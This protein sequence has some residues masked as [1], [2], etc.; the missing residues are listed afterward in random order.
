[1]LFGVAPIDPRTD[2]G[3]DAAAARD[4][5]ESS[6][7][8]AVELSRQLR[9]MACR[10]SA[11]L[12]PA[13]EEGECYPGFFRVGAD[14][15]AVVLARLCLTVRERDGCPEI[16]DL[17]VDPCVRTTLLPTATITELLAGQGSGGIDPAGGGDAG[18]PRVIGPRIEL[19]NG[20]RR[21]LIP[22][23]APLDRATVSRGVQITSFSPG[24]GGAGWVVEDIDDAD[25]RESG[26]LRA[27]VVE[28]AADQPDSRPGPG[29]RPRHRAAAGDGARLDRSGRRGPRRGPAGRPD[30]GPV[31]QPPRRPRRGVDPV[32][33]GARQARRSRATRA[34][35]G[36]G[37]QRG[38]SVRLAGADRNGGRTMSR[39]STGGGMAAPAQEAGA[40]GEGTVTSTLGGPVG[41]P[42]RADGPIVSFHPSDG[43]FLRA[44]HL[45]QLSAHTRA[46]GAAIGRATGTGV[47]YGFGVSLDTDRDTLEVRPGLAVNSAGEPLQS[48]EPVSLPLAGD[49]LPVVTADGFYLL[50]VIPDAHRFGSEA[51]Y[52]ALCADPCSGKDSSVAP[53]T[54]EGIALRLRADELPGLSGV[55][56]SRQRNWLA[57]QFFERERAAADPW[58][59][60][61]LSAN[62]VPE[63]DSRDWT[64][65]RGG[66]LGRAV[67]LAALLR[68]GGDWVLDVWIARRDLGEPPG[69]GTWRDRLAM[70]PWSVFVAQVLQ[71]HDQFAGAALPPMTVAKAAV[72]D[73]R[74][75][76][77]ETFLKSAAEGS[78]GRR[79]DVQA[80]TE[81]YQRAE[82][83]Y[84][85]LAAGRDLAQLGFDE[86]PPAGYL[87]YAALGQQ[88]EAALT[89]LLPGVQLRFCRAR[90]DHIVT[91]VA[92]AQH[93][94]R[95]PLSGQYGRP[96]V[97]ILVPSEPADLEPLLT[98]AYGW[99]AFVRRS[100][101]V[102]LDDVPEETYD[103]VSVMIAREFSDPL[104]EALRRGTIPPGVIPT[105]VVIAYPGDGPSC[106]RAPP[107]PP[108]R[109]TPAIR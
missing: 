52:G 91:A 69:T 18:G 22:V 44:E 31:G 13:E 48:S 49:H 71:F 30:R 16:L 89:K 45:A 25:Y 38:R 47:V 8:P 7:Q 59:V 76:L 32:A 54:M 61:G 4:A 82:P 86:L 15:T 34:T 40:A 68:I 109:R 60:P 24:G 46:L 41:E 29:D 57:S 36:R 42:V 2:A 80:F 87:P 92:A 63:L 37:G 77:T 108:W 72:V 6:A 5:V 102:C 33:A 55:D 93:L 20:G 83:A 65:P 70:R 96:Q 66:A 19:R 106:P 9:L 62:R 90:A 99:I 64:G 35:E 88:Y 105:G 103:N 98:P 85:P 12:R 27:I 67:P 39:K 43:V 11:E 53:W 79:K 73:E 3:A 97:D 21:L 95:I 100:D 84:L 78:L 74:A 56:P 107:S 23:T 104:L 26:D 1:M 10:D 75:R 58:L 28:L 51:S 17:A 50:E 101:R 14:D 94:D 81:A